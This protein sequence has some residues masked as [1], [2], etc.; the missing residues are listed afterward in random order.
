MTF[1]PRPDAKVDRWLKTRDTSELFT[2][3]MTAG[4][5][6]HG[7]DRLRPGRRREALDRWFVEAIRVGFAGRVLPFDLVAA[8]Q[9][10]GLRSLRPDA[11]AVDTQIAATALA[12]GLTLVTR[13]VEDF[14]FGGLSLFNPWSA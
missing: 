4:E 3:A 5:L 1:W 9:R 10:A 12:H 6:R 7:I 2:T 14:A 11:P 13:N 8:S